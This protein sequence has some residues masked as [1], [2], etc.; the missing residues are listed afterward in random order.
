MK[1]FRP[2]ASF[3]ENMFMWLKML[4]YI[5][6]RVLAAELALGWISD[7]E[8]LECYSLLETKINWMNLSAMIADL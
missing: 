6:I 2:K 8:S 5:C 3:G 1:T 7:H 4:F